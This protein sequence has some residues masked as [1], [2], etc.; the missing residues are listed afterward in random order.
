MLKIMDAATTPLEEIV[1]RNPAALPEVAARAAEIIDQVRAQGDAAL[2]RYSQELDGVALASLAVDDREWQE[3]CA[4]LSPDLQQVMVRAAENIRD[5]H[6]RQLPQGFV[7][8]RPGGETL[9]QRYTPL[10]KVGVYVPGGTASYPSTALMN[11]IPAR[12]A[13]VGEIIMATPPGPD[14]RVAPAILAAARLAGVD[15]IFKIGGAQA[16]AALAYGTES[17]PRVD[18]IVGPG[19]AYVAAAKRAVYGQ[20]AIDMIAGPSEIVIIADASADPRWLAADLLSQAEHDAMA[21]AVLLT[22][23]RD[24]AVEV[25]AQVAAQ[26][27]GLPRAEIARRAIEGQGKAVIV[28]DLAEACQIANA[29]APEHLELAVAQPF[30]YLPQIV[31]AGSIFLGQQVPEALGDYFAGPNHTLPTGGTARF[32]SPLGVEDFVK[33]S[34]FIYYPQAALADAC[35]AVVAFAQAEGLTAHARSMA[36]RRAAL[37]P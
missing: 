25:A 29:I 1:L 9:G 6:R 20:V 4:Q 30:D 8:S 17:I 15:R 2:Y 11:V 5:F 22:P 33:R 28:R 32:A 34:S 19:N 31:H 26:L 14:G 18:K 27:A 21:A 37:V 23:Q 10:D 16:I 35:D 13:G 3:G 7:Y 36:L 24:L 12:L